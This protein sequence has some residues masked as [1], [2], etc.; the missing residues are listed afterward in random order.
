MASVPST[1]TNRQAPTSF[2]TALSCRGSAEN[3]ETPERINKRTP[4]LVMDVYYIPSEVRFS[5]GAAFQNRAAGTPQ[6]LQVP[7]H[8]PRVDFAE[9]TGPTRGRQPNGRKGG[10]ALP[11]AFA[12]LSGQGS[13]LLR[14]NFRVGDDPLGTSFPRIGRTTAS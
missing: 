1:E 12:A 7:A 8:W 13:H 10:L 11:I 4:P 9:W 2:L 14:D 6:R 3:K 5:H